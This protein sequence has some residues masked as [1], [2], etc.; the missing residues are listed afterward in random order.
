M[1]AVYKTVGIKELTSTKAFTEESNY[2][3]CLTY[4]D[5]YLFCVNLLRPQFDE[6]LN[7]PE[8]SLI[9]TEVSDLGSLDEFLDNVLSILAKGKSLFL[10]D[11]QIEI[12]QNDYDILK[13]IK[14]QKKYI[15]KKIISEQQELKLT[16]DI[17]DNLIGRPKA[18]NNRLSNLVIELRQEG[19]SYSQI[20]SKIAELGES[21]ISKT[22]I[23]RILKTHEASND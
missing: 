22:S 21:P 20:Q 17:K 14:E 7:N 10:T 4:R 13:L 2:L 3:D 18:I 15:R 6:M 1:K 11:A 12:K 9:E 8:I 16:L 23:C 19:L 5:S